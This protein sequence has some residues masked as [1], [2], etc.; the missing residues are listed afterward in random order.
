MIFA[1]VRRKAGEAGRAKAVEDIVLRFLSEEDRWLASIGRLT[2]FLRGKDREWGHFLSLANGV[3]PGG[4]RSGAF[5]AELGGEVP[6]D[7]APLLASRLLEDLA[8]FITLGAD[9]QFSLIRY[10]PALSGSSSGGF[11]D[12]RALEKSLDGYILRNFY[13][14]LLEEEWDRLQA[15]CSPSS[16]ILLGLTI[17]FPGCL[18]GALFCAA[19]AKARFG[20]RVETMA[21]GG[22]I[23][24]EL[25]FLEGGDFFRYFDHLSL[26][27]GY[28]FLASLLPSP[29][30]PG[31]GR[32]GNEA[33]RAIDDEAARTV[34]PDYSQVDFSRYLLPVDDANPMHRLWSD[35]R[36]LKA[37]LAHGCYWH[38][39]SFCDITLDYICS[40]LPVDP[41]ALFFHLKEQA[42]KTGV[43]G[44][45]LVDEAAPPASLIRFSLRNRE[46]ALPLC[47]WGNIRF[48]RAY[49]PDAAAVLAAG[50]LMGVSAG[51]EVASEKGLQRL[52]KGL[53]LRDIVCVC[54]A[55]KE[56]GILIHAYLIYGYWDEDEEEIIDSAETIRQFFAEGLLDSAFWHK[57]VLTRH[58]RIYREKQRGLYPALKVTGDEGGCGFALNDLSFKGEEK[59]DRYTRPLDRLLAGWMAGDTESPVEKAFPFKVK[60]P[61]VPPDL[62]RRFLDEY[63]RDRDRGRAALP[64]KSPEGSRSGQV[65]F[66]GSRPVSGGGDLLWRWQLEDRRLNAGTAGPRI[67]SLLEEAGRGMETTEFY[68]ALEGILGA[69]GAAKAWRTLRR[70]GLVSLL[71]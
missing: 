4:P 64:G 71:F 6:P 2:A 20:S 51:I 58:S 67:A 13:G 18:P 60:P 54:A 14:P 47:F 28:G 53:A 12:F 69:A 41:D 16:R 39:C 7:L 50:G 19:S 17:P 52:G 32:E 68:R 40:F 26:D 65:I 70:G 43:R 8:D 11:R 44:V 59:F 31:S 42:E 49:S 56:A 30:C 10:L 45:H 62:V 15:L 22:Y 1:H 38:G 66:L 21:G 5:L 61:S 34:F 36:W 3:L 55:F 35:G 57:F 9:N 25:R 63:A 48:D 33:I 37:Y 29:D 27:R 46:A 23:N 24:T